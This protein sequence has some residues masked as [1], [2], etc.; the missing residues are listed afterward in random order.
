V[1]ASERALPA[2]LV[3][4]LFTDIEGSTRLFRQLGDEYVELLDAHDAALRTAIESHRGSVVKT[5]GDAFFAAF[6]DPSDAVL[7]AV[8]AQREL[9]GIT[10]RD[11]S[12]VR[13]RMGLHT[14]LASPRNDDYVALSVHQ[15][16]RIAAAAHGGQIVA[17][18]ATA[19]AV[20][21]P[22][23]MQLLPLGAHR[24]KDFDEPLPLFQIAGP[25]LGT[26]F[27]PLRAIRDASGNLPTDASTFIAREFELGRVCDLVAG[28]RVVTLAGAGGAGKTRLAMEAARRLLDDHRFD[29]AWL[30]D[31]TQTVNADDVPRTIG[32]T[33]GVANDAQLLD[34]IAAHLDERPCL[35]V[36]DNCEH[37]VA[38]VRSFL[39][40]GRAASTT[41]FLVTTQIPIG[42]D[43]ERIV[44]LGPLQAPAAD[45]D[46]DAL[47]QCPSVRLFV[48]RL[49][50][51]RPDFR[52]GPDNATAT[53]TICRAL[54]GL[55]LAL[56]LAAA[57]GAALSLDDIAHRLSDR[58]RVLRSTGRSGRHQTLE[59]AIAWSDSLCTEP[60]RL[61]LRR[62]GVFA[63][64]FTLRMAEWV[65]AFD[66]IDELDVLDIVCSLVD[67]SLVHVDDLAGATRY[68]LLESVRAFAL[69]ELAAADQARPV[70]ER[71]LEWALQLA[72]D[73]DLPHLMTGNALDDG[74]PTLEAALTTGDVDPAVALRAAD[75]LANHYRASGEA[76]RGVAVLARI[77]DRF[78]Q[79]AHERAYLLAR[80]ATL[81]IEL[82]DLAAGA[83]LLDEAESHL[84]GI[85]NPDLLS[86]ITGRR[87]LVAL[88]SDEPARAT[89]LLNEAFS[90][91]TTDSGRAVALVN[92]GVANAIS[93]EYEAARQNTETAFELFRAAGAVW[94]ESQCLGNLAEIWASLGDDEKSLRY[95][96]DALRARIELGAIDGVAFSIIGI[97]TN[98][99]RRGHDVLAAELIAGA[100]RLLDE[101]G[102]TMFA[103][104]RA[105]LEDTIVDLRSRLGADAFHER[106]Q[107]GAVKDVDELINGALSLR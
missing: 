54:D 7:A 18:A 65:V 82:N 51:V 11:G 86:L 53:A 47:T 97:G 59:A 46:L 49:T 44:R 40:Q 58:F 48:D 52:L 8:T 84:A 12:G 72:R 16:A 69:A 41:S 60:E 10:A 105:V 66:P 26:E 2:G 99:A 68:R 23:E 9:P 96:I 87:G 95:E 45:D 57:R 73:D 5:E 33:L 83:A 78:P 17:S 104:D 74:L 13:V 85:D 24:L 1:K 64:T 81:W 6:H 101:S 28:A 56:E 15:A 38:G 39:E 22:T 35:L 34:G 80:A 32:D 61:V 92:L 103:N 89:A 21:V 91:A 102:I 31:L 106:W 71:V 4:F 88:R 70:Y 42:V 62:L 50:A 79:P 36:L 90:L 30:V 75:R 20:T 27:P 43:G 107:A 67:R 100:S 29:E 37:V 93:G 63:G 94:D 77:L 19:E 14:G 98:A 25:G 76:R 3:T 55:P